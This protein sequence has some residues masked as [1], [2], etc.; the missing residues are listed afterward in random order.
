MDYWLKKLNGTIRGRINDFAM[1]DMKSAMHK[2]DEHLRTI[3]RVII[4]KQWK[5][6]SKQKW[7]ILKLGEPIWLVNKPSQ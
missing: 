6:L 3:M 7:G 5:A 1:E 2:I 4:W